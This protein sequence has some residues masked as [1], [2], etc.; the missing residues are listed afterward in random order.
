MN[1]SCAPAA[2]QINCLRDAKAAEQSAFTPVADERIVYEN[3]VQHYERASF[4]L[5][6]A[7]I[8]TNQYELEGFGE[9]AA[10]DS[11]ANKTFL[12]AA[13]TTSQ[14][15]QVYSRTIYRYGYY[16]NLSNISLAK[17]LGAY[18]APSPS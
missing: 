8:G 18:L 11:S 1:C 10:A 13:A 17:V 9:K 2:F 4:S 3:Y 14:L 7:I 15:R 5:V 16:G 12:C 6:P